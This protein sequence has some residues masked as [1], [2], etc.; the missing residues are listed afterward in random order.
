MHQTHN[1]NVKVI[2]AEIIESIF[3]VHAQN[4]LYQKLRAD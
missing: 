3:I 2:A 4:P 1:R